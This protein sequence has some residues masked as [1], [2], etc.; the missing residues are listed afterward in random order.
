MGSYG[1][2]SP[3]VGV[4]PLPLPNANSNPVG[5]SQVDQYPHTSPAYNQVVEDGRATPPVLE[6]SA[7]NNELPVERQIKLMRSVFDAGKAGLFH[8]LTRRRDATAP[9]TSVLNI[10]TLQHM[11]LRELQYEIADYVAEMFTNSEFRSQLRDL[12]PLS[13]LL[14]SYCE[15]HTTDLYIFVQTDPK[16]AKR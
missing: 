11:A 4:S 10:T 14:K 3:T 9:K 5:L 7:T 12:P 2:Y 8:T 13:E 1:S 15:P 6:S 16:M